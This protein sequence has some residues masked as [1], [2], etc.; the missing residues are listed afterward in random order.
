M[1]DRPIET[2]SYYFED[3]YV[4]LPIEKLLIV[5]MDLPIREVEMNVARPHN[6]RYV[7]KTVLSEKRVV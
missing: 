2:K 5:C 6:C 1:S 3:T 4:S 7:R